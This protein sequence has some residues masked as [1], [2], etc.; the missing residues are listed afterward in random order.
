VSGTA[1]TL[2]PAR[3]PRRN[4]ADVASA[5]VLIT[6]SLL[7]Y[8]VFVVGPTVVGIVLSFFSWD[9]FSPPRYVGLKN[10]D[11]LFHDAAML[12]ALG[13]TAKFL[14]LGVIPTVVIG[15]LLAV[16]VNVSIKGVGGVRTLYFVPLVTSV[17]VSSIIWAWIYQPQSGIVNRLLGLVGIDGPDWLTNTTWALPGL[18]IMLIWLSV[19]LVIILYLA[20]LQRIPETLYEAAKIDGAGAWARIWH[21]VWP[22]VSTTTILVLLLEIL[23]FTAAPFEIA[24]IMTDGGPLNSTESL[25]LYIYKTAFANSEV[26]YASALSILQFVVIALAVLLLRTLQQLG[27]RRSP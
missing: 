2:R 10:F 15:F 24:L 16:F 21:I 6:P 19:P 9:L 7:G 20:A 12:N 22:N 8:L 25:S 23:N 14:L 13:N 11:R 3:R 27:K 18:T 5:A 1:T 26:G 4:L 17:A